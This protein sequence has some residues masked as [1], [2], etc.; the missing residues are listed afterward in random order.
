MQVCTSLQTDNHAN[1]PSLSFLQTGCPSCRP[2]NNVK[3][4]KADNIIIVSIIVS[5][6]CLMVALAVD[7]SRSALV[8]CSGGITLQEV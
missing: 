2:T 4:L 5:D 3:A 6:I 1:T 8:L 7:V